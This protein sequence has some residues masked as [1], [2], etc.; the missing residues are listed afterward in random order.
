[1]AYLAC[2]SVKS[3]ETKKRAIQLMPVAPWSHREAVVA[4]VVTL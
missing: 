1:L 4:L 3:T 2:G